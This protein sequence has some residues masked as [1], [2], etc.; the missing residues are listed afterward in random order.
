MLLILWLMVAIAFV[1]AFVIGANDAANA[2]GTSYGSNATKLIYLLTLGAFF[3]L[4]GSAL[5]SSKLAAT[6]VYQIIP[7]IRTEPV[8]I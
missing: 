4:I 5:L 1:K 8:L 3:E 2:L 7:V 6:L